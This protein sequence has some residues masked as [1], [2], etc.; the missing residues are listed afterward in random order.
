MIEFPSDQKFN[1]LVKFVVMLVQLFIDKQQLSILCAL[2]TYYLCGYLE[3]LCCC[4][5]REGEW[6]TGVGM[7]ALSNQTVGSLLMAN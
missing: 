6:Q 3:Q 2:K 7:P 1:N 4:V 5:P